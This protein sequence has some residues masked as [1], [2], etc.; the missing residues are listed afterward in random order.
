MTPAARDHPQ[1]AL[2]LLFA[3]GESSAQALV[4]QIPSAVADR[5]LGQTLDDLPKS[6]RQAA[7]REATTAAA[8]LLDFDLIDVLVA[9]WRKHHDLTAAARRTMAAPGSV[10]LVDLAA[11]RI[12]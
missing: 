12:T 1:T 10:E 11:Y 9:G 3:P 4:P 8:G 6:I 7:V 2:D 5:S